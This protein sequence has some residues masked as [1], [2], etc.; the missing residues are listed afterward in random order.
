MTRK[1]SITS[2][3]HTIHNGESLA[4]LGIDD[5]ATVVASQTVKTMPVFDLIMALSV[6]GIIELGEWTPE[7]ERTVEF[8]LREH[9]VRI[10]RTGKDPHTGIDMVR[11]VAIG[12]KA[13]SLLFASQHLT[14][15]SDILLRMEGASDDTSE[16]DLA[17]AEMETNLS[18]AL[19]RI[20]MMR[21]KL[22]G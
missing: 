12:T 10:D 9:G 4:L 21:A 15:E 22:R 3:L 14:P 17:L 2:L 19:A 13:D 1:N 11:L 20:E 8:S 18:L 16:H 5:L 6:E 7:M